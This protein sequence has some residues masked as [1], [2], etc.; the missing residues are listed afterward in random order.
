[1]TVSPAAPPP[2]PSPPPPPGPERKSSRRQ[3]PEGPRLLPQP[4]L[5]LI[6][7]TVPLS[8]PGTP[9]KLARMLVEKKLAACV[10]ILPAIQSIYAW[11]GKVQ[12]DAE[13]LLI[14]KTTSRRCRSAA[15]ALKE[16]HPYDIPEILVIG[17][18]AA[19]EPYFLWVQSAVDGA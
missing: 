5:R 18:E 12:N 13:A 8:P 17:P 1:Q 2:P 9:A 11:E 19:N 3:P 7:C 4:D 10:N 14:I 6:L 16:H 15:H